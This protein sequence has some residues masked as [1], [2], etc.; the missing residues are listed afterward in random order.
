MDMQFTRGR[1]AAIAMMLEDLRAALSLDLDRVAMVAHDDYS[2]AP[3]WEA[4]V[5]TLSDAYLDLI[6]A[7]DRVGDVSCALWELTSGEGKA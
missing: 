2:D 6:R 5:K 1:L 3:E 7:R 4:V